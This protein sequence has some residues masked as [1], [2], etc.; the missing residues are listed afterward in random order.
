MAKMGRPSSY[1]PEL[2]ELIC[3]RLASG[4]ALVDICRDEG[5]PSD[6]T[7]RAWRDASDDFRSM[8]ARARE[9]SGDAYADRAVAEALQAQGDD[10]HAR[11][12]FDALRWKAGKVAPKVYGDRLQLDADVK[13]VMSISDTPMTQDQWAAQYAVGLGATTG[14]TKGSG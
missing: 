6:K 11:L 10:P 1:T 12:R 14:S 13:A 2:A 3:E 9:A 4:E 7:V 5:M 8:Y